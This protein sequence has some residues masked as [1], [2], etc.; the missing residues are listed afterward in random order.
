MFKRPHFIALGLIGLLALVILNLPQQTASQFRLAIG[1]LFLPLF[2]L[3]RSSQQLAREAG[4]A[5]T[6][7]AELLRQNEALRRTNQVLELAAA[8]ADALRRENDHFRQIYAWQLQSPWRNR[9]RLARVI[10]RDPANWWQ[11]VQID[12]GSRDSMQQG[13]PVLTPDGFLVGRIATVSLTRS[14]VMLI[15]ETHLATYP[16]TWRNPTKPWKMA[17]SWAPPAR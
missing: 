9:L 6:S 10:S 13:L 17:S 15:S 16:R 11:V 4:D 5:V 14:D 3:S 2:G 1:S 7:R 12:L 8:Q